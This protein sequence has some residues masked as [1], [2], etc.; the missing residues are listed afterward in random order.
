MLAA[1]SGCA[2]RSYTPA[3]LNLPLVA[4]SDIA[5]RLDDDNV[6]TALAANGHDTTGWPDINKQVAILH[7]IRPK[8]TTPTCISVAFILFILKTIYI[9]F[10]QI[11]QK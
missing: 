3:P 6:Q 4:E 5:R 10:A 9:L 7:P 11:L 2:W 1:I 8:P